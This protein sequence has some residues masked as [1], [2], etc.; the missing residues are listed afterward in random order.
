MMTSPSKLW[1][2]M[3]D[4]GLYISYIHKQ[5]VRTLCTSI[6]R[7]VK[8][9]TKLSEEFPITKGLRL[10]FYSKYACIQPYDDTCHYMGMSFE[11]DKLFTLHFAEDQVIFCLTIN[12]EKQNT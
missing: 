8:I 4:T 11:E 3:S 7:N 5:A 2:A 1:L 9:G 10:R 12:M 6:I